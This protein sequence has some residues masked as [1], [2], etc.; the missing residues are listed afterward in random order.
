MVKCDPLKHVSLHSICFVLAAIGLITLLVQW[1]SPG[2][3]LPLLRK[4]PYIFK[5]VPLGMFTL[6]FFLLGL[7]AWRFAKSQEPPLRPGPDR[8]D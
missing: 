8:H 6:F 5:F 1:L 7:S 3:Y 4:W 2:G